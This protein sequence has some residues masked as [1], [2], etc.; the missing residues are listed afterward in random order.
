MK[1]KPR[2]A[3]PG[4]ARGAHRGHGARREGKPRLG[5]GRRAV[6]RE[7]TVRGEPVVVEEVE[8][9]RAGRRRQHGDG[10]HGEDPRGRH[11]AGQAGRADAAARG[12]LEHAVPD[13]GRHRA[14]PAAHHLGAVRA[15]VAAPADQDLGPESPFQV[16]PGPDQQHLN[17]LGRQ[18][19]DQAEVDVVPAAQIERLLLVGRHA[20]HRVPRH[21]PEIGVALAGPRGR[22]VGERRLHRAAPAA[23]RAGQRV[24]PRTEQLGV[25]QA[26]DVRGGNKKR[27]AQCDLRHFA[28]PEDLPAVP[29][30]P[31][32]VGV[33]ELGQRTGQLRTQVGRYLGVI[34]AEKLEQTGAPSHLF[35]VTSG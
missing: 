25:R 24:K 23:L 15:S 4:R 3:G 27:V 31:V 28:I 11:I 30:E 12:V 5:Q 7:L 19:E 22:L 34:H 8:Y 29:E 33:K 17:V 26:P 21:Q 6:H 20:R 16:L 2:P 32:T 14:R 13:F 1:L 10:E 9:L 35:K 18:A